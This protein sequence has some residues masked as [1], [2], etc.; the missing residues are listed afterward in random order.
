MYVPILVLYFLFLRIIIDK[1]SKLKVK[2][3]YIH[4]YASHKYE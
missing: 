3:I 1:K 2:I 4:Y